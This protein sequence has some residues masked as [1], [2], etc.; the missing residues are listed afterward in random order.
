MRVNKLHLYPA[1]AAICCFFSPWAG[2]LAADQ[3]ALLS[4]LSSADSARAAQI[5]REL[6]LEWDRSGSSSVDFLL[7]R[8]REALDEDDLDAAIEHFSA[9]TDHAPDFATG[10]RMRAT[11]L[12]RSERIGPA[13][14]DLGRAVQLNPNDWN[15]LF[16]LASVFNEIGQPERAAHALQMILD[17]HPHHEEA[18]TAMG[19][20]EQHLLGRSL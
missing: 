15:T 10:W 18:N 16:G 7:R 9:V 4:E 14:D 17:L 12:F 8:G 3:Q 1:V 11:A 19:S 13:I 20:V 5:A 6:E 2:L